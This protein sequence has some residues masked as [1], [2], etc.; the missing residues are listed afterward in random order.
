M[1]P[2]P[3]AARKSSG[4]TSKGKA[5]KRGAGQSLAITNSLTL[6][7]SDHVSGDPPTIVS[8]RD[9]GAK[10]HHFGLGLVQQIMA[11]SAS[12]KGGD[13]L[14]DIKFKMIISMIKDMKPQ[15]HVHAALALQMAAVH[16]NVMKFSN[17][18][19][20]STTQAEVVINGRLLA[21]LMRTYL[22][23]M[24]THQ[25]YGRANEQDRRSQVAGSQNAAALP[26]NTAPPPLAITYAKSTA[27]PPV[28]EPRRVRVP[29]V[30]LKK[31]E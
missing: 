3:Q 15:D 22:E 28:S 8:T 29:R 31:H 11:A 30:P 4:P 25:R 16:Q 20:R 14:D 23:Q 12:N 10:D 26:N 6:V 17:R 27:M 19:G 21:S 5:S 1:K 7:C 2:I 13:D 9:L 18:L 24:E